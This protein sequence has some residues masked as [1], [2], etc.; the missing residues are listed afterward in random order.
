MS[1]D[2]YETETKGKVDVVVV[3]D[4]IPYLPVDKYGL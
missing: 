3:P 2:L 1:I 4:S